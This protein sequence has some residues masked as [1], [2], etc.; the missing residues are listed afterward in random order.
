MSVKGNMK[1]GY[2]LGGGAARGLSHIGVLKVLEE[3]GI[4][5]DIIAGTSV[6]AIVGAL[7]AGGYKP[8]EI[9][10]LIL[11]MD[12]KQ[13]VSLVDMT[14]PRT[15]LLQGKRVLTLLKSVLRDLTFSQLR[16]EFACVATDIIDG[17]QVVLRDGSLIDAVRASISIPGIFTPVT[18]KGRFLVDGGLIN[19]VPVS[20]CRDMGAGYVIGVN[21]IPDPGRAICNLNT[22]DEQY[23]V[24]VL[25]QLKETENKTEL[26]TLSRIDS[27]SLRSRIADIEN[28]TKL[29]ITAHRLK[30]RSGILKSPD[31]SQVN[32]VR[33]ARTK[34]P[35]LFHVL[36][37]T[38]T[39]V[40]YRIAMENLKGAD[41]TISPD[42]EAIGF[43]QFNNAAQAI[44]A[45]EQ[46]ARRA[47]D[48]D[49]ML[50]L[51]RQS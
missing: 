51:L 8:S 14:L 41:L 27:H 30:G 28:A 3:H 31:P 21:V 38:W 19:T 1:I 42:V 47:L 20:V 45:G 29:F 9:E 17:K 35:G 12:W 50:S 26:D 22:K 4:F 2:A 25:N 18:I 5:P 6:G 46:A 49:K 16:W 34:P 40:E 44:A 48:G 39:I 33:R 15:G 10:S 23:P 7:Y 13:L 36:S 43:W 24:Y 37:Q 32:P 11:G